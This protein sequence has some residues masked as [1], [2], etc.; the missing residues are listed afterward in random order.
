MSSFSVL[1]HGKVSPITI[2]I[3]LGNQ[4]ERKDA[5]YKNMVT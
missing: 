3:G 4:K 2:L 1:E 5:G